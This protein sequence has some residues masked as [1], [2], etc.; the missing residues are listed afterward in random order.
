[1]EIWKIQKRK[2]KT[3]H[4]LTKNIYGFSFK[5]AFSAAG[6]PYPFLAEEGTAALISPV[7]DEAGIR[8]P[9]VV[10]VWAT[11]ESKVFLEWE[12][13]SRDGRREERTRELSS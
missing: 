1:M 10:W 7:G 2:R 6:P 8:D 4:D 3:M 9:T 13:F 11:T 5:K 12:E